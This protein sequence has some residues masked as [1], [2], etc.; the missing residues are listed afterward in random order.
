VS[1]KGLTQLAPRQKLE[2]EITY[3]DG[4]V[5]KVTLNNRILTLDEIEYYK[6]GGILHYVLRQLAVA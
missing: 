3:A 2:A 5:K 6:N 1:I 4:S